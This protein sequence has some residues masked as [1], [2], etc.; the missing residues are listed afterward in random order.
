MKNTLTFLAKT[1]FELYISTGRILNSD[2]KMMLSLGIPGT[3]MLD[4]VSDFLVLRPPHLKPTPLDQK[5]P[6]ST[7][8][9]CFFFP[10]ILLSLAKIGR[11]AIEELTYFRS[12]SDMN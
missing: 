4:S 11:N 5:S 10:E 7:G 2:P 6:A 3:F 12:K 8:V 1:E 9:A